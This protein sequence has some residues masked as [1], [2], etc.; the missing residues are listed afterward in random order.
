MTS[1]CELN[2]LLETLADSEIGL[3]SQS[4]QRLFALIYA[5]LYKLAQ[6]RLRRERA[7]HTLQPTA[8]VNEI[9]LRLVSPDQ[10]RQW[11]NTGHFFS[12]AARAMRQILIENARRK[13]AQKR[14]ADGKRVDL[15]VDQAICVFDHQT[16]I[17][18]HE[19]ML[20]LEQVEPIKAKLV[21]LRF[22]GGLSIEQACAVLKI[23]RATAHR[24]WCQARAWLFLR[25]SSPKL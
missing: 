12:A 5:E 6:D 14:C 7:G 20:E 16:L 22:F 11:D 24:Y 17:E 19:A 15:S 21:E 18:L 10:D 1:E 3:E 2:M 4:S 23:S 13:Q 25:I 8:L 9:Y